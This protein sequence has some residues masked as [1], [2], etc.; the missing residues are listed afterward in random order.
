MYSFFC[1]FK[2]RLIFFFFLPLVALGLPFRT[3]AFSSGLASWW[4]AAFLLPALLLLQ[5]SGCRHV[6]FSSCHAGTQALWRTGSEC[7]SV[8]AAHGASLLRAPWKLPGPGIN[9]VTSALTGRFST[10]RLPRKPSV[11][12]LTKFLLKISPCHLLPF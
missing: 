7:S 10:T 3:W 11:S 1:I 9:P 12:C 5:T 4:C 2:K 8:V 6:G